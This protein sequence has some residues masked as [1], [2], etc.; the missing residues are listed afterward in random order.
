MRR[1]YAF[2]GWKI[3]SFKWCRFIPA[4]NYVLKV[5]NRNTAFIIKFEQI[6]HLVLVFLLLPLSRKM[7]VGIYPPGL[8]PISCYWFLTEIL[9]LLCFPV[10]IE[11]GKSHEM[12]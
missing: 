2:G 12:D 10:C 9:V 1:A 4:E 6:S 11:E 3:K 8:E 7:P 5:N